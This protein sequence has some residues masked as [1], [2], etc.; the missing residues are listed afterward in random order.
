M[1]WFFRFHSLAL[2]KFIIQK[3]GQ[4]SEND[5]K[6]ITQRLSQIFASLIFESRAL[7][8]V[9]VLHFGPDARSASLLSQIKTVCF[10]LQIPR[11]V[12]DTDK[13]KVF[14]RS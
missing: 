13:S 1:L 11:T 9:N 6:I 10:I 5:Q 3:I 7:F 14:R 12:S 8:T 2:S 4:L